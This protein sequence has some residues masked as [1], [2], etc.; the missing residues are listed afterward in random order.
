M[1]IVFVHFGPRLPKYLLL[2]LKRTCDSLPSAQITLI[3]DQVHQI[4][5][6]REN[7]RIHLM[8]LSDEYSILN[9][10][11]SHR[12]DFRNNFWFSSLARLVA[13]SDY[14]IA[15]QT[16]VLHIESDVI[17]SKDFPVSKFALLDRQFAYTLIGPQSAVASVMWI[18]NHDA[19]VFLKNFII[20]SVV[21]DPN[22]TDMKILGKLQAQN[23]DLVR[24]L[25][26]FPVGETSAYSGLNSKITEDFLYTENLFGGFFD[27]ADIGQ[28]LLGDDPRNHRGFKVLRRQLTS[29]FLSPRSLHY[30][31]S[32]V[33][34]FLDIPMGE[35]TS[36]YSLHIHSKNQKAFGSNSSRKCLQ[37]GEHDQKAP[38]KLEFVVGIFLK[39]VLLS[40]LRRFKVLK[41][42]L[43]R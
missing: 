43:S 13:L 15:T 30:S 2:N 38:E 33:R 36:L 8:H 24:S 19:A 28:Y 27:A 5:L 25:A 3:T 4:E 31:Y 21:D 10:G 32:S 26:S 7:F 9:L 11:L 6:G 29:S 14:V 37:K 12:K 18:A 42:T 22:T 23:P 20:A 34:E 16:P 17:I 35:N 1:E 41:E 39:A 40:L